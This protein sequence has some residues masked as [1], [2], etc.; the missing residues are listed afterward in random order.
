MTLK[1][2][3][4]TKLNN[5]DKFVIYNRLGVL[6]EKKTLAA[7]GEI[8]E[9]TRERVR[10]L[11]ARGL[12]E[13]RSAIDSKIIIDENIPI[14]IKNAEQFLSIEELSLSNIEYSRI[15][16]V[17]LM[18]SVYEDLISFEE[19]N[20]LNNTS[21]LY[22][23]GID[24]YTKLLEIRK[25]LK[26]ATNF[27]QINTLCHKYSIPKNLLIKIKDTIVQEDMIAISTNDNIFY[28]Q[29]TLGR[30]EKTLEENHRPMKLSEVAKQS[31]LTLNQVRGAIVRVP[32]IVNVGLST[33]A[34]KQWGYLDGH[35]ADVAYHYLTEANIPMSTKQITKLV[36]K[37]RLVK[38]SSIYMSMKIDPRFAQLCNGYWVLSE[39]GYENLKPNHREERKHYKID[40]RT[41][42]D[43]SLSNTE[44]QSLKQILKKIFTKYQEDAPSD[45]MTYHNLLQILRREGSVELL[46]QGRFALFKRK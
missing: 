16:Y 37:Q 41:A 45:Y 43:Y 11:E 31:G 25:E 18:A 6:G 4:E 17:T 29:G 19:F 13:I 42:L 44:F 23:A 34:K 46:K 9:V 15:F 22:P 24:L 39:W 36:S 26:E 8:L 5:S 14:L 1:T 7:I 10:Q 28:Q 20:L 30:V 38:S 2:F 27:L 35:S 12:K 40:P 33:Y 3:I 21:I 32:G